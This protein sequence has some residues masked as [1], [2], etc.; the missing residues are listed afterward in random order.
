[1]A[2]LIVA[3]APIALQ[4]VG[5]LIQRGALKAEMGKKYIDAIE[6]YSKESQDFSVRLKTQYE[7]MIAKHLSEEAG[8]EQK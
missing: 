7:D 1:M 5:F 2:T 6:K 3:L 4:I 8:N